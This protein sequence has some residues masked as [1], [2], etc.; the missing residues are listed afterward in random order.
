MGM[1]AFFGGVAIFVA[2]IGW[3]FR[4]GYQTAL[5]DV[6]RYTAPTPSPHTG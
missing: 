3:G 5:A 2:G 1:L 4:V 6:S